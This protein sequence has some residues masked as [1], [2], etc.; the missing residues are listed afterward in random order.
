MEKPGNCPFCGGE[1]AV[2]S[3]RTPT[4]GGKSFMKGWVGCPACG[5]YKQWAHDPSGAIK[6]WNRREAPKL[7]RYDD[8]MT[9]PSGLLSD[10]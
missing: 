2:K 5:V 3:C 8:D 9:R 6:V 4:S 7:L 1:G 10:D